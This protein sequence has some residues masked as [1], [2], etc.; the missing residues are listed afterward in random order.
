MQKKLPNQIKNRK[1]RQQA[2]T[3]RSYLNENPPAGGHVRTKYLLSNER[4]EFLGDSILSFI[5][6]SYLYTH[7]AHLPEGDLTNLRSLLVQAKTL[8]DISRELDFG[9]HLRL[10]RGEDESGGRE[11]STILANTYEAYIGALFLDQGLTTVEA[12]LQKTL[13]PKIEELIRK[14]SFKDDKSLLQELVQERRLLP[15]VYKI[16]TSEG[17]DHAKVFTVGVFINDR[18]EAK[19]EGR[20]KSE[21]EK[22][23]ATKALAKWIKTG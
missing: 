13:F 3:H 5:V 2:F 6:S 22:Q 17:P 4:L 20:S 7:F 16:L 9:S 1:L 23:A 10:S 14:R 19:A 21:A 11:N 18:L 15:P 8:A 12:F